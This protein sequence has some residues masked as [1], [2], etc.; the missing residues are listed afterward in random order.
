MRPL[1]YTE[2][3]EHLTDAIKRGLLAPHSKLPSEREMTTSFHINRNTVRHA[4]N[5]LES[6]GYI[7]RA[8]R[9]GWYANGARLVYN[10]ANHVNFSQLVLEQNMEPSWQVISTETFA[11]NKTLAAKF[12]LQPG[13]TLYLN[14]EIGAIDGLKVYYAEVFF[15]AQLCPG[16]LPKII[17]G[18]ITTVL[19]KDYKIDPKQTE[20]LIRPVRLDKEVQKQLGL[21]T[22]TPGTIYPAKK[23]DSAGENC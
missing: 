15:N 21:P 20:L 6:E 7:Y 14:R 16:I 10:P 8:S 3:K 4:L 19:Q 2:V 11:A 13:D 5:Q 9:R 17:E 12:D 23:S 1:E 22:G 18:S